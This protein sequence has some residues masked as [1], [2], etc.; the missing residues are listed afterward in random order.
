MFF[1]VLQENDEN[2]EDDET[3]SSPSD[4]ENEGAIVKKTGVSDALGTNS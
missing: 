4:S 1:S 2:S 3:Y